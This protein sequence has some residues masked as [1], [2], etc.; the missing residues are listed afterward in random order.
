MYG[1][2]VFD[3]LATKEKNPAR[4]TQL[5]DSLMMIYDLRI[6]NCGEEQSVM[7]RKAFFAYKHMINGDD[8]DQLL[9]I[10]DADFNVNGMSVPD[11]LHQPYWQAVRMNKLKK[12]NLTDE[13]VLTRYDNLKGI[14]HGRIFSYFFK[15]S[16][17][18]IGT[19]LIGNTISLVLYGIFMA[20]LIEPR[21]RDLLPAVLVNDGAILML[22]TFNFYTPRSF[23]CRIPSEKSFPD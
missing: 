15:N 6:T 22:Q 4:K 11:Q 13:E 12:K 14:L 19:T 17:L 20:Q 21:L 3:G 9:A 1:E 16:S 8:V 23:Y 7:N 5:I 2:E 18:F 10:M